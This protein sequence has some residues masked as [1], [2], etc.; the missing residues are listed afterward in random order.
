[1]S[2][3]FV[4]KLGPE[5]APAGGQNAKKGVPVPK[6]GSQPAKQQ[7]QAAKRAPSPPPE[8]PK[9]KKGWF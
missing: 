9:K 3:W 1:M 4:D 6:P 2:D 5:T 7:Q 8:P